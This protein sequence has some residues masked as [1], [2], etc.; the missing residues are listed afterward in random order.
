MARLVT[1]ITSSSLRYQT[2]KRWFQCDIYVYVLYGPEPQA[3]EGIGLCRASPLWPLA[4][5][6]YSLTTGLVA[7]D[8]QTQRRSLSGPKSCLRG[9]WI[10]GRAL[11]TSVAVCSIELLGLLAGSRYARSRVE[12]VGC[13]QALGEGL[14]VL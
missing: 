6:E 12:V 10:D 3:H 9:E 13:A 14:E 1:Q 11:S 4:P 8:L 2:G 5:Q 7:R